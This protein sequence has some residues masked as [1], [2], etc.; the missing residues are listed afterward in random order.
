MTDYEIAVTET[1]N[2]CDQ[3]LFPCDPN[4]ENSNK[5]RT[6]CIKHEA[7]VVKCEPPNHQTIIDC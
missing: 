6:A 2:A 5:K 7:N 1:I 3:G 4:T